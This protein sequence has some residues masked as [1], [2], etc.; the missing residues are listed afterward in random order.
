MIHLLQKEKVMDVGKVIRTYWTDKS[1]ALYLQLRPRIWFCPAQNK[2]CGW[3]RSRD[4]VTY[5][6]STL[7]IAHPFP[8]SDT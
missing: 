5:I 3:S 8:A 7:S 2:Y 4:M 1:H 6:Y